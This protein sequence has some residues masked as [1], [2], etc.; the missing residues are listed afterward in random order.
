MAEVHVHV[1][2]AKPRVHPARSTI[3]WADRAALGIVMGVAAYVIE[4]AV[5]RG[6][7]KANEESASKR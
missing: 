2:T 3:R 1:A 4:R 6:T 5:V 7:K